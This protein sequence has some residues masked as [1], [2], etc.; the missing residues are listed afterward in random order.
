MVNISERPPEAADRA[1]PGH[2][3]GD[4]IVGAMG[5]SAVATL[6]ERTTRLGMLIKVENKTTEHVAAA[7]SDNVV[8]L[9]EHLARS[10]T[11]DQGTEMATHSAFTGRDRH[12][13]LLL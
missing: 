4:L 13:R 10:I 8:R 12:P 5:R 3:E 2:W 6:V 1:V 11:W 7:L 9:P